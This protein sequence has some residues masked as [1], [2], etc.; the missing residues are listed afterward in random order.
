[1]RAIHVT[2]YGG[3]EVLQEVELERPE[4][5]AGEIRIDV[6]A[7]GVN[8]ADI[9]RRS[10]ASRNAQSPPYVPGIEAAG[11]IDA[12]GDGVEF[13]VGDRV[14]AT[15]SEGAYATSLVTDT[16][17]VYPIPDS[18]SFE[19]AAGVPVQFI[20]AYN[21]LHGWG[22]L[23]AGERVL[24]HAAAGGVGS[25]A[26]QLAAAAGAE[27]FATASTDAKLDL[28]RELGADHAIDYA[29]TDVA[30]AVSE[31]TDDEG[32]DLVLDGVGGDAFAASV[33]AL[34][35]VGRI[36]TFGMASGSIPTVATPRLLFEN[37]SVVGY[38]LEHA[39]EHVPDRVETA[40]PDLLDHL[41]AGRVD[42]VIGGTFDL[43]DA[44]AAHDALESR[45]T[46][47]KVVLEP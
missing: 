35:P 2:A 4:P 1:M 39:L 36:V 38:H 33:E 25:L 19:A 12:V 13:A 34:A 46:V 47:G 42:P 17:G 21:C 43:T 20:T 28:A 31:R 7:I 24:I 10:G 11:T 37:R 45:E 15:V 14:T 3:P 29:E 18:L 16:K 32:V 9:K 8:Y 26:V 22:G 44:R 23:E 27:V 5:M 6:E 40:I 41:T 30:A